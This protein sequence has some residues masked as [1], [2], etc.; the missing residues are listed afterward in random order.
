MIRC[1]GQMGQG[2]GHG[3]GIYI[4]CI[5]NVLGMYYHLVMYA[6]YEGQRWD[7]CINIYY[8][9]LGRYLV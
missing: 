3:Q 6:V 2:Q 8:L 7:I 4:Q 1:W 9:L 5:D